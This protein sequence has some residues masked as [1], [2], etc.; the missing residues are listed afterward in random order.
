MKVI[1][2]FYKYDIIA[3]QLLGLV[4]GLILFFAYSHRYQ[5]EIFEAI[6]RTQH[7]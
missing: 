5:L 4:I 7:Y 2:A 6:E 3:A 1:I